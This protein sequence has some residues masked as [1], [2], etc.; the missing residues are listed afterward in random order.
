MRPDGNNV[1]VDAESARLA[2]AQIYYAGAAQL[3]QGQ[4]ANLK[5]VI[6]GE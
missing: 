2:Q 3:I 5:S 1:D 6:K 4:F